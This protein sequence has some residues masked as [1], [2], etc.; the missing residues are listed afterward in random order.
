MICVN[1]FAVY[2]MAQRGSS[3]RNSLRISQCSLPS[4]SAVFMVLMVY[5]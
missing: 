1:T 4:Q 5:G 3:Q 2:I